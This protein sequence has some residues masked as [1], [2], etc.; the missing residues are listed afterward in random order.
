MDRETFLLASGSDSRN[1]TMSVVFHFVT[2]GVLSWTVDRDVYLVAFFHN[3]SGAD[4]IIAGHNPGNVSGDQVLAPSRVIYDDVVPPSHTGLR[5]RFL[6][7]ELIWIR[8]QSG[9]ELYV[10]L[11]LEPL[12]SL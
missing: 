1:P 10:T 11:I 2:S 6:K 4:I 12:E 5:H 8:N 9:T 7:D 3:S